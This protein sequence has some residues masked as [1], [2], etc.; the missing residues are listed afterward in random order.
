[1]EQSDEVLN[2]VQEVLRGLMV[3]LIAGTG[4]DPARLASGIKVFAT[5]PQIDNT[6]R[7]M[8]LDLAE[9]AGMLAKG[10]RTPL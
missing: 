5:N 4:A 10:K 7:L 1:M 6:S 3:G 9:G 8:L 2:I